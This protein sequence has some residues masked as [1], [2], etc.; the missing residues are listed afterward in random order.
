MDTSGVSRNLGTPQ[1]PVNDLDRSPSM[2]NE[3]LVSAIWENV[4]T[5]TIPPYVRD[6]SDVLRLPAFAF[7]T[8]HS[9]CG[10]RSPGSRDTNLLGS[11]YTP[12]ESGDHTPEPVSTA[13]TAASWSYLT[14]VDMVGSRITGSVVALGNSVADGCGST[15]SANHR[16]P[17]RLTTPPAPTAPA[18]APRRAERRHQGQPRTAERHRP[19]RPAHLAPDRHGGHPRQ[20]RSGGSRDRPHFDEAGPQTAAAKIDLHSPTEKDTHEHEISHTGWC[21]PGS[22]TGACRLPRQHLQTVNRWS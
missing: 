12:R 13:N 15:A 1:A 22:E 17:D 14:G 10:R 2:P 20:S 16:R 19:Q 7:F 5:S 9:A 11:P 3:R 21:R 8:A 6:S 4:R 18:R